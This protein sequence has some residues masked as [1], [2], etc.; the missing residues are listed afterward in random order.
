MSRS[1]NRRVTTW[2]ATTALVVPASLLGAT[3]AHAAA[4]PAL[5]DADATAACNQT[6]AAG[7]LFDGR[8]LVIVGTAGKKN[9][10]M[11][12]RED[13]IIFGQ[14]MNDFLWGGGGN[15]ILCGGAGDDKLYGG[16]GNDTLIGGTGA[17]LLNGGT[18]HDVEDGG[19]S[20]D[21]DRITQNS[22]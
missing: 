19:A 16:S 13:D 17:D 18:G 9:H 11:G 21:G 14:D 20:T 8:Y 22:P 4:D 6:P 15:D 1:T 3:A 10:L 5:S 12:G 2:I 7:T